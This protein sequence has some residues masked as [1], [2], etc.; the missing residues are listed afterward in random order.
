MKK[1][2]ITI[3]SG[4]L[5]VGLSA[6]AEK[7]KFDPTYISPMHYLS[8]NCNQISLEMQRVSTKLEQMVE[9][10][11]SDTQDTAG[12]VFDTA[13]AAFAIAKNGSYTKQNNKDRTAYERLSNQ[14][15]ILEQTAIN[16]ECAMYK[17]K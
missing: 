6:C 3:L 11:Q 5:I 4:I 10:D 16:K 17:K 7:N 13:L 15:D 1:L 12:K 8:F 2:N 9:K 14:Y